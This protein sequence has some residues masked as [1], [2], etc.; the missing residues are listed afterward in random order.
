MEWA[1]LFFLEDE[2]P[3]D[4][5]NDVLPDC[6]K[7]IAEEKIEHSLGLISKLESGERVFNAEE[8]S[9]LLDGLDTVL[10]DGW[11]EDSLQEL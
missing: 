11:R 10:K 4:F 9:W 1:R 5:V 6:L 8:I 7:G 2:L 3:E